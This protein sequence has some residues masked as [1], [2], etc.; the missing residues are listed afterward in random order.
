MPSSPVIFPG[1]LFPKGNF[2]RENL[3][4][5]HPLAPEDK[6]IFQRLSVA[7]KIAAVE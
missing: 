4:M 6:I 2:L 5:G 7:G 3:E 1:L